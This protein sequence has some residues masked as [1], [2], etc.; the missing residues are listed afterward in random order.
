MYVSC[1]ACSGHDPGDV[2][3]TLPTLL[4]PAA[5]AV[6]LYVAARPGEP[7]G[8]RAAGAVA[9]VCLATGYAVWHARGQRLHDGL[10]ILALLPAVP[11]AVWIAV[12]GL[13]L[14]H[15]EPA[16]RRLELEV[17]PGIALV[18]LTATILGYHGRH[19]PRS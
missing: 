1:S 18:G 2:R 3:I 16:S 8:A 11:A 17:G 5:V 4:T 15:A 10:A 6:A 9:V 7:A 12:G 19:D 13:A 14:A